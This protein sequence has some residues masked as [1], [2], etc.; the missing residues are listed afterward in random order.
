MGPMGSLIL[1][2]SYGFLAGN[3]KVRKQAFQSMKK[4]A[5]LGIDALNKGGA[6]DVPKT[7]DSTVSRAE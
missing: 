2:M 4:I 1:G 3:P 7:D 6:D 5:G